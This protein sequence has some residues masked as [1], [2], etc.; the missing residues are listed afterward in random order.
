M[1]QDTQHTPAF[2]TYPVPDQFGQI[3]VNF[4][5]SKLEIGAFIIAAGIGTEIAN[6][7]PETVADLSIQIAKDIITKCDQLLLEDTR[8]ATSKII[9]DGI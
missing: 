7:E 1:K 9:T 2:P 6:L 3:I 4:G 8:P 5:S